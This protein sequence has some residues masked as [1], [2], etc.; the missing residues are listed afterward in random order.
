MECFTQKV[1]DLAWTQSVPPAVAGGSVIRMLNQQQYRTSHQ[2]PPAT[3]GGT[4][5][6]QQQSLTFCAKL[7]WNYGMLCLKSPFHSHRALARCKRTDI[8][9]NCFNGFPTHFEGNR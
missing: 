9:R 3:A 7:L 1:V 8:G 2:L 4:D 6:V 5:C